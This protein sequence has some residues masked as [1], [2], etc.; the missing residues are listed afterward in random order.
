MRYTAW[1]ERSVTASTSYRLSDDLKRRLA[2]RAATEGITET[3]LVSRV[4]DEGLRTT[5]HPG[6]VYRDGPS[7]RRAALAGGPDVWEVVL[8]VRHAPGRG[9]DKIADAAEQTDLPDRLVRL[10][11]D[12]AAAYPEEIEQRIALND[13]AAEQ[14][15]RVAEQRARLMAS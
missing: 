1:K 2:E 13:A 15:R 4:L 7:G 5:Q 10:A 8:A 3:A 6:I 12:F 9:D 14:A 11:I